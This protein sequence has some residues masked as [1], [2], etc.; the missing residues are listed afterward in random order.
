MPSS[1]LDCYC[2]A[3]PPARPAAGYNGLLHT[4]AQLRIQG[5]PWRNSG[6]SEQLSPGQYT[7]EFKEIEGWA[8]PNNLR[9]TLEQGQTAT[10]V[11]RYVP[12]SKLSDDVTS[13]LVPLTVQFTDQSEDDRALS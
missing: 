9:V 2:A 11:G 10:A 7:I 4:G 1:G 5:G 8:R 12:T 6:A 13:G 3:S